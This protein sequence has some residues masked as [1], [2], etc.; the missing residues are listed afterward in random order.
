M[1]NTPQ[2][3]NSL[4]KLP[5]IL[6]TQTGMNTRLHN[7]DTPLAI[8][9]LPKHNPK[10]HENTVI[11]SGTIVPRPSRPRGS[12]TGDMHAP[13]PADWKT[14]SLACSFLL[15]AFDALLLFCGERIKEILQLVASRGEAYERRQ[16][17]I[18]VYRDEV[19]ETRVPKGS[20]AVTFWVT[21]REESQRRGNRL[22]SSRIQE[23]LP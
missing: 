19:G 16:N 14:R 12:E 2:F 23:S 13:R 4:P 18:A 6:R 20:N 10:R 9:F 17:V 5:I 8:E 22:V 1:K 11:Q 3:R 15:H 21:I 7:W